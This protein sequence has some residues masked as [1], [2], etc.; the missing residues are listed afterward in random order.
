[1]K[2]LGGWFAQADHYNFHNEY[3]IHAHLRSNCNTLSK[4]TNFNK[5]SFFLKKEWQY[6]IP[7][8]PSGHRINKNL[9]P[10]VKMVQFPNTFPY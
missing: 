4:G 8:H 5:L 1:M 2:L 6:W 3:T 7:L 10:T 9:R